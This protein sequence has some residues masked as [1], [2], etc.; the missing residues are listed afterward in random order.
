LRE[1]H[2]RNHIRA[3]TGAGL[4][5]GAEIRITLGHHTGKRRRDFRVIEQHTVVF[6]L[7][8]GRLQQALSALKRGL[9]GFHLGFRRQIAAL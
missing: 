7:R 9:A 1:A 4:H 3:G 2:Q 5:Q 8:L 6:L